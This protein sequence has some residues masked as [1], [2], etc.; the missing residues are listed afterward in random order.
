MAVDTPS[1]ERFSHEILNANP[2]AYL[3]VRRSRNGVRGPWRCG[4]RF[5]KQCYRKWGD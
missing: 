2:F 5:R 3:D 4:G 1:T